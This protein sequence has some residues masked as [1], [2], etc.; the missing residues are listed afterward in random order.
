[1]REDDAAVRRRAWVEGRIAVD[2]KTS[3]TEHLITGGWVKVSRENSEHGVVVKIPDHVT[4]CWQR[5]NVLNVAHG[6]I[7]F[8]V[9]R[10]AGVRFRRDKLITIA[11]GSLAIEQGMGCDFIEPRHDWVSG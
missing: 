11:V 2:I 1:M 6:R 10:E 8:A 4:A 9:W 7:V 5:S 3:A